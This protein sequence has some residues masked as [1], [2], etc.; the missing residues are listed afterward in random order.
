MPAPTGRP[1]MT[2][3]SPRSARS[4]PRPSAGRPIRRSARWPSS[5][6]PWRRTPS[7]ARASCGSAHPP[8]CPTR[9]CSASGQ[10]PEFSDEGRPRTSREQKSA[11]AQDGRRPQGPQT[12]PEMNGH[13]ARGR[14]RPDPARRGG[15]LPLQRAQGPAA[16]RRRQRA[17]VDSLP[18]RRRARLVPGHAGAL[19]RPRARSWPTTTTSASI[20]IRCSTTRSRP[21]ASTSS[22]SRTRSTAA[23]R[24]SSIASPSA[25]CRS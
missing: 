7:P 5:R 2:S 16:G 23:A 11:I 14:Q 17:G 18:R 6:S 21:T 19:R 9:W 25:N 10:L 12:E 20:P 24:I 4:S 22:R 3:C 13:A 15:P 8:G 1:R